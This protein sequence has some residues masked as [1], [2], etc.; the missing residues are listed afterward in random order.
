MKASPRLSRVT[1]QQASDRQQR[2][3][4]AL[5]RADISIVP[6]AAV[7]RGS[8]HWW[9]RL[10]MQLEGIIMNFKCAWVSARRRGLGDKLAP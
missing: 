10:G 1:Y 7:L 9:L 8:R 3:C 5:L 6:E 2:T 4:H